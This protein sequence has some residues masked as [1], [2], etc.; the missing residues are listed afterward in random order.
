[1]Q[2]IAARS[3]PPAPSTL[4]RHQSGPPGPHGKRRVSSCAGRPGVLRIERFLKPQRAGRSAMRDA[5]CHAGSGP[6]DEAARFAGVHCMIRR[7]QG[8]TTAGLRPLR[9]LLYSCRGLV[10]EPVA[11]AAPGNDVSPGPLL[12]LACA[13]SVL[14]PRPTDIPTPWSRSRFVNPRSGGQSRAGTAARTRA[15]TARAASRHSGPRPRRFH[16]VARLT[17]RPGQDSNLRPAA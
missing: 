5:S 3:H 10:D 17:E 2:S 13:S 11:D 14:A 9:G 6:A 4:V 16:T 1:M 8:A 12:Q 7:D 15:A